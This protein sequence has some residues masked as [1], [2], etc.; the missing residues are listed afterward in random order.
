[1]SATPET[2]ELHRFLS[3]FDTAL[4]QQTLHKL[5]LSKYHGSE[6]LQRIV[7]RPV[8]LKQQPWLSF[9]FSYKTND[10]TKNYTLQQ[11]PEEIFNLLQQHFRSA[12]LFTATAETQ[13]TVSKK[14][15]YLYHSKTVQ[16]PATVA[17]LQHNRDKQRYLELSS[18]FLTE[19]GITDQQQQLIPAMSRKWKQINKFIEILAGALKE[20]G[21]DNSP[22]VHVADFG[23]GKAYLTFAM[24]HYLTQ[25]LQLNAEV[26][27][28]ELR[29][30][31][32]DLCNQTAAKLQLQ[33]IQFE[34]GDVK[35]FQAR[36][37]NV[38]VAL[39]AC[40]TATDYAIHMGIATGAD[41]IMCS[42]CCHKQIRPQIQL[43]PTL[44]PMLQFGIHLGQE[45]EML[46]DSIR[47]LLLQAHGYD[48]K[49]FEFISLEHTSKN[50]M[51][52]A[53]RQK[54]PK[55]N[56]DILQKIRDLKAFYGIKEHCL[57][58]LLQQPQ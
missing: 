42:P 4:T 54:Q 1:M 49:V 7:I 23:S 11:A 35:Y 44:A 33:R 13:L 53:T 51:I 10:V 55:N 21:L 8:L 47:A 12:H 26:T 46:T 29:Q 14:G 2:P 38:M 52:L 18:P 48:T 28:V 34:Q 15:K 58:S 43:P 36:N 31:L 57:E 25:Q 17:T 50:K 5:I 27:G 16:Q 45:A 39:H 37:I 9:V 41:I 6:P 3:E 40:D 20:T 30:S 56:Q 22:S 24:H 19:L 32:V